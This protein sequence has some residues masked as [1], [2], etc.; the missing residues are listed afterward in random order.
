M[1][2][3]LSESHKIRYG[4]FIE[5]ID[6]KVAPFA[7]Q[8]DIEQAVPRDIIMS[9][10]KVG[11]LGCAIP[12]QYGGQGQDFLTFGLLNEA[13][14]RGSASL[15][16]LFNVHNMVA[17][18]LLK[19]GTEKQKEYWL[20]LLSSGD[21][22]AAFALTEPGAGSDIQAIKTTYKENGDMLILNGKKRWITFGAA[23]DILLVFGKMKEL[24]VACIV[25]RGT[26]GFKVTPIKEMLG[27]RAAHLAL[28]EFDNCEVK[29]ENMIGKPG[30]ALSF[31]APYALK[32]GR[33]S[34]ACASLGVLRACFRACAAYALQRKTFATLLADHGMVRTLMTDMG[35]DLEAA[36]LLC[37]YACR[38]E[39]AK[40]PDANE[41]ILLAKYYASTAASR[42]ASK[43]VQ[44]M[45]AVG[46]NENL[47]VSRYYRDA[48][49]MEIIEGSSQVLQMLLGKSFCKKGTGN[50]APD[51]NS[52]RK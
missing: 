20:P 23:A 21:I 2:D 46:C 43:A 52:E 10:A 36:G 14:S 5:F 41:K 42:H 18:T 40:A 35:V 25:E 48:K 3:L 9:C 11:Y 30:I 31:I 47:P 50:P 24:P 13:V 1:I 27:F 38:S 19:W 29:K 26:P 7:S 28:L 8:W 37:W 44:I 4:E 6:K 22:L 17:Q 49:V 16:G 12:R 51:R 32:F 15:G 34:V 45:G 39:D 33:L